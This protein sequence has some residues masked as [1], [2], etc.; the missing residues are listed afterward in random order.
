MSV[1]RL[2]ELVHIIELHRSLTHTQVVLAIIEKFS[3]EVLPAGRRAV[4]DSA[5][6]KAHDPIA[7]GGAFAVAAAQTSGGIVLTVI[8]SSICL[9][10]SC[11]S[12]G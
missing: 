5:Y 1:I 11:K 3:I 12:S 2:G 10:S 7:Y 6:I 8:L 9:K 4:W